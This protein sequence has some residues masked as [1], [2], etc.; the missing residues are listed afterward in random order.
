MNVS[1]CHWTNTEC[2][3]PMNSNYSNWIH[4]I[5]STVA[6]NLNRTESKHTK[7]LWS[8]LFCLARNRFNYWAWVEQTL[9]KRS[10]FTFNQHRYTRPF[11]TRNVGEKNREN[12]TRKI[13]NAKRNKRNETKQKPTDQNWNN[14]DGW[15][16][17]IRLFHPV[18]PTICLFLFVPF[19]FWCLLCFVA[20]RRQGVK[21]FTAQLVGHLI[22]VFAFLSG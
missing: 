21:A 8:K 16:F 7:I 11:S 6:A 12:K 2:Q 4:S 13:T 17:I 20:F 10:A 9:L 3:K 22:F 15:I 18:N 5:D 1:Y 19:L 14:L